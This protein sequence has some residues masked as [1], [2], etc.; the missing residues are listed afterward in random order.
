M[1]AGTVAF[2]GEPAN[3]DHSI[4]G[5]RQRR[6]SDAFRMG[7][8]TAPS[9]VPTARRP[10]RDIGKTGVQKFGNTIS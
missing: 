4:N 9:A 10:P 1:P 8:T 7:E 2:S 6:R 3:F 5:W